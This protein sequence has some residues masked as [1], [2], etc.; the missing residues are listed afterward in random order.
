MILK[1]IETC[2]DATLTTNSINIFNSVD[3][4]LD[5]R[6]SRVYKTEAGITTAEIVFNCGS[7]VAVSGVAIANHNITSSV[8]TLKLQGNATD[9][10]TSP[11]VDETLTWDSGIITK[12]ITEASYQYWRIQIIDATNP[13]TYIKLGRV[14]IGESYRTAGNQVMI[15]HDRKSASLKT[16]SIAGQSYTDRRYQYSL[17]STKWPLL[18]EEQNNKVLSI[19]ESVDVGTPFFVTF[20]K[21]GSI[22][23]TLYV[24]IDEDGLKSTPLGNRNLYTMGMDFRQEV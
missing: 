7:A 9:V 23:G 8:T 2:K 22:L 1:A 24:T 5:S 6:L 3:N 15:P 16:R 18:T 13:D 11:S 14:W 4:I 19:F 21:A 12:N 20:D 10:W 17:V